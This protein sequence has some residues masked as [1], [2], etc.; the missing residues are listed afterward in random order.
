LALG[1][2]DIQ[3]GD[4]KQAVSGAGTVILFA[5]RIAHAVNMEAKGELVWKSSSSQLVQISVYAFL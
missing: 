3:M 4:S 1:F 2:G 5:V